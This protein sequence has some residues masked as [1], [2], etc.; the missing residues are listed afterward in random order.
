MREIISIH[1]RQRGD[2][3]EYN[4]NMVRTRNYISRIKHGFMLVFTGVVVLSVPGE[5]K[6]GGGVPVRNHIKVSDVGETNKVGGFLYSD[7]LRPDAT[8]ANKQDIPV[9]FGSFV[10]SRSLLASV[11]G[12]VKNEWRQILQDNL[13]LQTARG[14][15]ADTIADGHMGLAD[16]WQ[17]SSQEIYLQLAQTTTDSVLGV[18]AADAEERA[19]VIRSVDWDLQLPVGDKDFQLGVNFLGPLHEKPDEAFLWQLRSYA[20]QNRTKG[21]NF[22]LIYRQARKGMFADDEAMYGGNA[23]LDYESGNDGDFWRWSLGVEYRSELLALYG[24]RYLALTDGEIQEDEYVYSADGYDVEAAWQLP[25]HPNVSGFVGYYLWEGENG[26]DDLKGIRYGTRLSFGED[27]AQM[28]L[29]FDSPEGSSKVKW[30]LQVSY[31]HKFGVP[32]SGAVE[33]TERQFDPRNYFYDAVKREYAQKIRRSSGGGGWRAAVVGLTGNAATLYAQLSNDE[34]LTTLV[35]EKELPYSFNMLVN[36]TLAISTDIGASVLGDRD[37]FAMDLSTD[38]AVGSVTVSFIDEGR[39]LRLFPG[40]KVSLHHNGRRKPNI[41]Y[42]AAAISMTLSPQQEQ[43][44]LQAWVDDDTLAVSLY[45]GAVAFAQNNAASVLVLGREAE[46]RVWTMDGV[47]VVG[48]CGSGKERKNFVDDDGVAINAK[49]YC[50]PIVLEPVG[51]ITVNAGL[52][53]PIFLTNISASG[54]SGI[55]RYSVVAGTDFSFQDADLFLSPPKNFYL[56]TATVEVSDDTGVSTPGTLVVTVERAVDA[57]MA[58]LSRGSYTVAHLEGRVI[59]TLSPNTGSPSYTFVLEDEAG[60]FGLVAAADDLSAELRINAVEG[61]ALF[62]AT[63]KI[64]NINQVAI[65]N[66]FT[67][68]VLPPVAAQA[69]NTRHLVENNFIGAV[70]TITPSGGNGNYVYHKIA[71]ATDSFSTP[72][73]DSNGVLSI[74][75]VNAVGTQI[76]QVTVEVRDT[77]RTARMATVA[78]AVTVAGLSFSPLTVTSGMPAAGNILIDHFAEIESARGCE[79]NGKIGFRITGDSL[80][81]TEDTT[82][83]KI[84]NSFDSG[85][86]GITVSVNLA[87]SYVYVI[88]VRASC[89]DDYLSFSGAYRL[90]VANGSNEVFVPLLEAHANRTYTEDLQFHP[91]VFYIPPLRYTLVAGG[92]YRNNK[93]DAYLFTMDDV[94]GMLMVSGGDE[95]DGLYNNPYVLSV[96]ISDSASQRL[97]TAVSVV[98]ISL[99]VPATKDDLDSVGIT[100]ITPTGE[101][102]A[103][104]KNLPATEYFELLA[105]SRDGVKIAVETGNILALKSDDGSFVIVLEGGDEINFLDASA[106]DIRV[107]YTVLATV[108]SGVQVIIAPLLDLVPNHFSS[109]I[110]HCLAGTTSCAFRNPTTS[111]LFSQSFSA[112]PSVLDDFSDEQMLAGHSSDFTLSPPF[113]MAD[114]KRADNWK[115]WSASH[116]MVNDYRSDT[117]AMRLPTRQAMDKFSY[118]WGLRQNVWAAQSPTSIAPSQ[119][120]IRHTAKANHNDFFMLCYPPGLF[121]FNKHGKAFVEAQMFHHQGVSC[122]A[123]ERRYLTLQGNLGR[124]AGYA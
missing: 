69:V 119:L 7:W 59:E 11:Y 79:V 66:V 77:F 94:N 17:H 39:Q 24:N 89:G 101:F 34:V 10:L 60:V 37:S 55:Y 76:L 57:I 82:D 93:D 113:F 107:G 102:S 33:T 85:R 56:L 83:T 41:E 117:L 92:E 90:D 96:E 52:S 40:A 68:S 63:V 95:R 9:T 38:L 91:P 88:T 45:E 71:D 105:K 2:R 115:V 44:D 18:M 25:E 86:Y 4:I 120:P 31:L 36:T 97:T 30:G 23:F 122:G 78:V 46:A 65:D 26:D 14:W 6:G 111:K 21:G 100:D 28:E 47:T 54:G 8:A 80:P 87:G 112:T 74:A 15:L 32:T 109:G 53:P 106:E 116:F 81:A 3:W 29:E 103:G 61:P 75:M 12:E 72:D 42:M 35:G 99:L 27:G 13:G 62:I 73:P 51:A 49:T 98:L 123:M 20:G 16:K 22:G 19:I 67:V 108:G 43:T 104:G 110:W 114:K 121:L 5:T 50:A 124:H 1:R 70:A 84:R 58:N 48:G 118:L 64:N